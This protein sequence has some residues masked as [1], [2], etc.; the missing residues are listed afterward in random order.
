MFSFDNAQILDGICQDLLTG[1]WERGQRRAAINKLFNG[2]PPYTE[3]EVEENRIKVN[4]NTLQ[5]PR[6]A[7]E[8]RAQ[9][10][11]GFMTPG[12][13]FSAT[14]DMGPKHRRGM[15]SGVVCKEANRPLKDSIQYF[16]TLRSKFASLVLHGIAPCVWENR[17]TVVPRAIGVEDALLPSNTLL[18]F[19]NLPIIVLRRSFTRLELTQL[20][21]GVRRDPGWNMEMVRRCFEWLDKEMVTMQ[22]TTNQELWSPE[23]WEERI[24]ESG[25]FEGLDQVPTVDCF[26]IYGYVEGTSKQRSGWVRRIILD[27]YANPPGSTVRLGEKREEAAR[28]TAMKDAKGTDLSKPEKTDFLYT[29]DGKPVADSWQH[30]VSFQFADL[31]AVAPFRYHSVRSLGWMLYASCHLVNR[32]TCKFYESVFEALMQYFKVNSQEDAQRAMKLEL[33]NMGLIDET[34]KPV[35]AAERWQVRA[36][37]VE[38]GLTTSQQAVQDNSRSWTQNV[39]QG[40]KG[41]TEKTKFQVMAEVQAMNALVSAAMSQSYEYQ[42]FEYREMFRRLLK[43]GSKDPVARAFRVN[44][45]RQ[46]VPENVLTPEAWDIQTERMLGAGNQTLEMVIAQGLME[47]RQTL[48]PQPQ[49]EVS[50]IFVQALTHQ[51][52]LVDLLVPEKPEISDSIHDAE[53]TFATLMLG[54]PCQP[55]SGLNAI[56]VAG[57][58]IKMMEARVQQIMKSGGVGTPQDVIGLQTAAR[59]AAAYIQQLSQDEAEKKNAKALADM[60]GKVMNEVKAMAQR[61]QEMAKKAAQSQQGNGGMDGEAKGKIIASLITAK[62][63][64]E[65]AKKSHAQKTAQRQ[66]TFEQKQ[67]QDA[68]QHAADIQ[69]QDLAAAAEVRRG[70][71]RAF[72]EPTGGEQ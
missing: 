64:A 41:Q 54:I 28:K 1:D 37:L 39:Q 15:W 44:C 12:R 18:G 36:D 8:A 68:E 16:E 11:N 49:R 30:I 3:D 20:T 60:L 58:T 59:Y 42:K 62:A 67:R 33:A 2:A 50:R 31:S 25:G 52:Y 45:M 55:K 40:P 5:G 70:N 4:V 17:D 65:I 9:F 71:M 57:A 61:Q 48:D 14:T 24:K 51:P 38:L 46:G 21:L 56:E 6:L 63:K 7:H 13:Y 26:D 32:M 47:I 22:N 43:P 69:A 10:L 35:P 27:G 53:Q 19:S 29:S 34:I 23:K 66:V 72:N